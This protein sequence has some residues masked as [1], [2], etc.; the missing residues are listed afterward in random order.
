MVRAVALALALS[1]VAEV[2]AL[3]TGRIPYVSG[4]VALASVSYLFE[5]VDQW[6]KERA[7]EPEAAAEPVTAAVTEAVSEAVRVPV[8]VQG[9]ATSFQLPLH[10]TISVSPGGPSRL[11]ALEQPRGAGDAAE[12]RTDIGDRPV[13]A[14]HL[15]AELADDRHQLLQRA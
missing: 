10:S 11:T 1:F 9:G 5:A 4:L 13:E 2:L 12:Q 3:L 7:P 6:R 14:V 8:P 15:G